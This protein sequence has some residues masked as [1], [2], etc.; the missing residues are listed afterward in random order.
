MLS[1]ILKDFIKCQHKNACNAQSEGYCP[2][3][4]K[5]IKKSYYVIRCSHCG[6]KR[7][8]KKTFKGITPT[9]KFCTNCGEQEF[10]IEKYNK[11]NFS[12]IN[13]AIEVK[14]VIED[15]SPINELEIWI[16]ESKTPPRQ[17]KEA[18]SLIGEVKYLSTNSF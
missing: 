12:D 5:F 14:E 1:A 16:E 8:A 15:D 3:C 9:E 17:N 13:Y 6:I 4:G 2:D 10:V 7:I 18:P 11:L